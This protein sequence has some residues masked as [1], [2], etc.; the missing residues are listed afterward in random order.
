M[1]LL[2]NFRHLHIESHQ[3]IIRTGYQSRPIFQKPV[4]SLVIRRFNSPGDNENFPILLY[5]KSSRGER[6][7]PFRGFNYQYTAGKSA[8]NPVA[9]EKIGR[10][11]VMADRKFGDN[12][13]AVFQYFFGEFSVLP[14]VDIVRRRPENGNGFSTA[15]QRAPMR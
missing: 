6:T 9:D 1:R 3:N 8:D 5:G 7:G 15:I 4:G 14:R 13:A 11:I 12:T 2:T 10:I